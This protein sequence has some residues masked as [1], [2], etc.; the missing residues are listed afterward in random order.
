[1]F[2]RKNVQGG[3]NDHN[4]R[5]SAKGPEGHNII[6]STT[7]V[8]GSVIAENDFRIDGSFK[9]NLNCTAKVIIGEEGKFE[10][11][12]TCENAVIDRKSTRL[13]SSHVAISY[14]V[15]CLKKK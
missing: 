7:S 14:A 8:E 6:I 5:S 11:D 13:N 4:V 9:G 3:K 10:G 12:I 2:G 15:F 1:M